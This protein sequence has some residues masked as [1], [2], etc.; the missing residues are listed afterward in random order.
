MFFFEKPFHFKLCKAKNQYEQIT[1][2]DPPSMN[3]KDISGN[4]PHIQPT[5]YAEPARALHVKEAGI[6]LTAGTAV[7][8]PGLTARISYGFQFSV[9]I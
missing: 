7:T 8:P 4:A 6:D 2:D 9:I 1:R 3:V 5:M